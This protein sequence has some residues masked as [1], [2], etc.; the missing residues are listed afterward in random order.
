MNRVLTVGLILAMALY[1]LSHVVTWPLL[2]RLG[3]PVSMDVIVHWSG[4]AKQPARASEDS[5]CF[6]KPD[7]RV[8][9]TFEPCRN[10]I[11]DAVWP[12]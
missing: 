2:Q 5:Y 7:P 12:L 10:L 9:G 11:G 4:P 8:L 3:R 6:T 1:L